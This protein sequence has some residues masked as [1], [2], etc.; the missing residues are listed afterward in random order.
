M[1]ITNAS[2]N[3]GSDINGFL[4]MYVPWSFL[5]RAAS[6]GV[7]YTLNIWLLPWLDCERSLHFK[8]E[9]CCLQAALTG[10]RPDSL[11][12]LI[13]AAKPSPQE[14]ALVTDLQTKLQS[15][16]VLPFACLPLRL[17]ITKSS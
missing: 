8:E 6:P 1:V 10:R 4:L 13:A 3:D 5:E 14:S 2:D 17:S 11:T 12:A 7:T 16:Q 9:A 15:L